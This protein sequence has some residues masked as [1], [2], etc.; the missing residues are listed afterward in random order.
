MRDFPHLAVIPPL[1][2]SDW[3]WKIT[4]PSFNQSD[5]KRKTNHDL[6]D[7]LWLILVR[8][9][10]VRTSCPLCNWAL[11]FNK[12]VL[13]LLFLNQKLLDLPLLVFY[14]PRMRQL[15]FDSDR[16]LVSSLVCFPS[17]WLA[18]VICLVWASWRSVV[19]RSE[20]EIF[21][22]LVTFSTT[23]SRYILFIYRKQ[24]E[25]MLRAA[26]EV[27]VR[28]KEHFLAVQAARDR[29]EFERVLK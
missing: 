8:V 25:E 12:S 7:F 28:N 21:L 26:R 17:F 16:D 13:L 4:P 10:G 9:L 11:A 6:I 1:D 29:A 5:A 15:S 23:F 27:Q 3:S 2:L 18:T 20:S 22:F 19:C 14:L 24:T